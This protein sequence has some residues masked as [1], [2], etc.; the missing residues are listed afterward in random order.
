VSY[1][2]KEYRDIADAI[3]S[4]L[5]SGV[6]EQKFMY[7]P[8]GGEYTLRIRKKRRWSGSR[9]AWTATPTYSRRTWTTP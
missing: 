8:D 6:V 1:V 5:A 3:L 2:P 4:Q 9:E 7:L